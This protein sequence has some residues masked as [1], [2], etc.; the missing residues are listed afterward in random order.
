MSM[1]LV[2]SLEYFNPNDLG[3]STCHIIGCGSVGG[4]IAVALARLGITRITLWDFDEV[5]SKNIA[6]Q[7][8][9]SQDV[10][11]LKVSALAEILSEINPDIGEHL[12]LKPEGWSGE[13]LSGYVFMAPDSIDVRR[14]IV[15]KN[16]YNTMK[17]VFDFRTRLEDAQSF[18]ADWSDPAQI[19]NLLATMDFTHEEAAESTPVSACGTVLGVGSIPRMIADVGVNNFLNFVRKGILKKV[20]ILNGFD[21]GLD[22][23]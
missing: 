2:K 18:A 11:K 5:E 12:K 23:F 13:S 17:A 9:R 20:I 8:F 4:N 14:Q 22:A 7:V 3:V 15:E 10:G 1:N 16:R 19:D 21:F 6:N